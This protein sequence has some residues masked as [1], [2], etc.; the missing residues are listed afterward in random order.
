MTGLVAQQQCV[1][2]LQLPLADCAVV[3]LSWFGDTG[4]VTAIGEQSVKSLVSPAAMARM[5]V[6]E[7]ITNIAACKITNMSS[8]RCEANW[9]W[10]AKMPGEGA[11]IYEA[12]KS[13]RDI[14]LSLGIA[15]DGG[16]DSLSMVSRTLFALYVSHSCSRQL[17]L[18]K[19]H[20]LIPSKLQE[21]W[22]SVAML[23][24]QIYER[25]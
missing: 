9:M 19:R 11:K 24:C 7:M 16:K 6:T 4:I 23:L 15:V 17:E 5:A 18:L 20:L 2:P 12:V 1:G 13:L 8:I 25:N 21:P 22:Y 14:L 3:A 10:P